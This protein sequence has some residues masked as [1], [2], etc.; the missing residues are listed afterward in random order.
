MPT[1]RPKVIYV[2]GAGRSGS[3]ILGVALGSC[4]GVCYAGELDAWFS[5]SGVPNF[6]NAE[7]RSFW[8]AVA[9]RM[10]DDHGLF[11]DAAYRLLERSPAAFRVV[12]GPRL[13]DF[14]RRYREANA[15][16]YESIAA[17]AAAEAVVDTSHFPL[18]ARQLQKARTIDLYLLYLVRRP[19][20]V[21]AAFRRK[22]VAQPSKGGVAANAYL[23]LTYLLSITA[24]TRQP[25]RR[26]LM[27][28]YEEFIADPKA[29]VRQVL[30]MAG[31]RSA[32]LPAPGAVLSTGVAFQ[33]NRILG[34]EHVVLKSA[35]V[36]YSLAERALALPQLPWRIIAALL[37]PRFGRRRN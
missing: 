3:T 28:S 16:L 19:E 17:T 1:S 22:D 33:G 5:R 2:M 9:E 21:I 31:L 29:A 24:F 11:G 15:A 13:R 8:S 27:L 34:R 6:E 12:R 32:E 23:S 20:G 7:R 26:R 30:T 14:E 10:P 4:D 35:P 36:R 37:R 25:R 18:R